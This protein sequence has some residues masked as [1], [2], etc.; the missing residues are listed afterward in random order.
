VYGGHAMGD[1]TLAGRLPG[2]RVPTLV[3]WGAA[4]RMIPI[5]H[6]YAYAGAIEG[7]KL[8]LLPEAGHLPQLEAPAELLAAV[9]DFAR[10]HT[11]GSAAETGTAS[12]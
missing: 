4:D 1:P 6:G 12:A 8:K 9:S 3:V 11:T 7:A 5:E 2:I 10:S